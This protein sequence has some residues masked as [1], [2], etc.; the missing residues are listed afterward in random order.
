MNLNYVYFN[1]RPSKEDT[2]R[3][4]NNLLELKNK[5]IGYNHNTKKMDTLEG[6]MDTKSIEEFIN[7]YSDIPYFE[8]Y[9]YHSDLNNYLKNKKNN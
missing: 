1:Y 8:S 7:L 2:K 3:T 5:R 6:I 9:T 4:R